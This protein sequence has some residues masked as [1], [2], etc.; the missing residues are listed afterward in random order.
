LHVATYLHTRGLTNIVTI[1]HSGFEVLKPTCA[2]ERVPTAQSELVF[3]L[4]IAAFT[5]AFRV[6]Y[7]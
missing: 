2:A 7:K 3:K 4:F 6:I 1:R 5:L